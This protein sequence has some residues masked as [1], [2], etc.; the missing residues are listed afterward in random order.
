[1]FV[2][3]VRIGS[4][5]IAECL[6]I[7]TVLLAIPALAQPRRQPETMTQRHGLIMCAHLPGLP[8][9]PVDGGAL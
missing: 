9:T 7:L 2:N 5:R 8:E 4:V 6:C 1:M 3:A